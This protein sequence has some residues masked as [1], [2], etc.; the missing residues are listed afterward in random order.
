MLLKME[1]NNRTQ[2]KNAIRFLFLVTFLNLTLMYNWLHLSSYSDPE[3]RL[4]EL[5]GRVP[6]SDPLIDATHTKNKPCKDLAFSAFCM[7]KPLI[8]SYEGL[9]RNVGISLTV[10][11]LKLSPVFW[12]HGQPAKAMFS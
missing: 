10:L 4:G 7:I 5:E 11:C 9:N 12:V 2:C 8:I 1:P 6:S 3:G